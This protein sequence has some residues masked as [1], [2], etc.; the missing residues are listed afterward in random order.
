M[1]HIAA[2]VLRIAARAAARLYEESSKF[3]NIQTEYAYM[4]LL[5]A[6]HDYEGT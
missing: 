1:N 5:L 6:A 2:L 3:K 4:D